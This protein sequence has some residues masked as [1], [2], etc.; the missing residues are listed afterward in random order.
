MRRVTTAP[1]GP[2]AKARS[3]RGVRITS[4]GVAPER[5]S[6]PQRD[7]A[8]N[9]HSPQ[10]VERSQLRNVKAWNESTAILRR[11][12]TGAFDRARR[13]RRDAP[14]SNSRGPMIRRRLAFPVAA[15]SIGG[16]HGDFARCSGFL[17]AEI[18]V[19]AATLGG[20]ARD[21]PHPL[22]RDSKPCSCGAQPKRSVHLSDFKSRTGRVPREWQPLGGTS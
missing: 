18:V 5:A 17:P 9:H 3:K 19:E 4:P 2:L 11:R 8:M 15:F 1:S 12:L 6:A 21:L 7:R 13:N 20:P 16:S 14:E 10:S 22:R